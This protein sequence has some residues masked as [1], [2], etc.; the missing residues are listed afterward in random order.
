MVNPQGVHGVGNKSVGEIVGVSGK[1]GG[2]GR[3][4]ERKSRKGRKRDSE[5]RKRKKLSALPHSRSST[6]PL[7]IH[8]SLPLSYVT[9]KLKLFI[10]VVCPKRFDVT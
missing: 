9:N 10:V 6:P 7:A 1:E 4:G 5:K 3:A 8:L 2:R